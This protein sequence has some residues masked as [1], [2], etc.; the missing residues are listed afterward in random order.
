MSKK[1]QNLKRINDRVYSY[2][3]ALYMAFYSRR[4][5]IDVVKRWRGFG[6]KYLLLLV[7]IAVIPMSGRIIYKFNHAFDDQLITLINEIPPLDIRNG[8]LVFDKPMPYIIKDK[9]GADSIII[10][11]TGKV[12][13]I[14][15]THPNL[16]MLITKD[17]LYFLSPSI[18][19]FPSSPEFSTA[20]V[21]TEPLAGINETFVTNDWVKS[22]GI[23]YSKWIVS[24]LIYPITIS[25]IFGMVAALSLVI[26]M[27][28]KAISWL[29]FKT[30]LTFKET[31]RLIVVASTGQTLIFLPLIGFNLMTEWIQMLCITMTFIYFSFAVLAVRREIKQLVRT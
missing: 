21:I 30:K 12:T 31:C 14:D 24:V 1:Q 23:L 18:H 2:R 3:Q 9:T 8:E 4:L 28:A 13:Q 16:M 7:I 11:T 20:S 22:S 29:I 10:D 5:Y 27:L 26:T 15:K 25:M 19:L 17:T 6:F